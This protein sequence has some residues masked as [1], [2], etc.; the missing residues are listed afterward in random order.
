MESLCNKSTKKLLNKEETSPNHRL[1]VH[2]RQRFHTTAVDD[3]KDD[4]V[5]NNNSTLPR[6]LQVGQL[7][8]IL[9]AH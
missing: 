9:I 8:F 3:A 5:N 1:S 6:V 7:F 2:R 4:N